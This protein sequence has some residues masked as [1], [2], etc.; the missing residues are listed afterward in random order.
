MNRIG[1]GV[2][3][4]NLAASVPGATKAI[5]ATTVEMLLQRITDAVGNGNS[6]VLNGFGT[7]EPRHRAA[8]EGRNPRTG[9]PVQIAETTAMGF[10]P[11]KA[12]G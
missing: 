4:D 12:R 7:F 2:L 6:V 1:K 8:R 5:V 3:I 9:A 11:A 10:R